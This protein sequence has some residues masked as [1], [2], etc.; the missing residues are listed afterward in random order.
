[1]LPKTRD[2]IALLQRWLIRL[3]DLPPAS[4]DPQQQA[5]QA[6][7]RDFQETLARRSPFW[8]LGTSLAFEL[9]VLTCAVWLFCRTDY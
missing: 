5:M 7:Q 1:M 2:T 4:G 8:I 6:A 9:V 3:A